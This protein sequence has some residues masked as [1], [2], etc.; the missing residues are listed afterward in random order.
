MNPHD[1]TI[2]EYDY[3]LP[4]DRIAK[5]PSKVRDESGL[6]IYQN[7]TI[8]GGLFFQMPKLLRSGDLIVLNDTRVIPARLILTK[9]TG[10]Q[11]EIFCLEPLHLSHQDAMA[12]KGEVSWK[13]LIGGAK[14][15]KGD[16]PLSTEL[17]VRGQLLSLKC[18]KVEKAEDYFVIRFFWTHPDANFSEIIEAAGQIPLPPYFNRNADADDLDRY[19][20]VFARFQGSVAAPT[21]ALHFTDRTF[22]ALAAEGVDVGYLTLHVGAGTFKPVSSVK[23]G[24]H[25]MHTEAFSVPVDLIEKIRDKKENRTIAVGTTSMRTLESLYWL[26]CKLLLGRYEANENRFLLKQWDAYEMKDCRIST[27]DALNALVEYCKKTGKERFDAATA[28]MIAPGYDFKIVHALITNFHMPKSTLLVL[29][30][31]FIG[32]DWKRVYQYALNENFRFLSYGDSSILFR[33]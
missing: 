13:C 23:L 11:I 17:S 15:W 2:E 33:V 30:S 32:D 8:S 28:I 16:Q 26:G 3:V 22:S 27:A 21:A 18:E 6:L 24:G 20:T 5:H 1:I 19:Q 7:H 12:A 4:D 10:G 31:A 29:V 9:E 25:D 14:K